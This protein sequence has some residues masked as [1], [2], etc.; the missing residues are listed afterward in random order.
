MGGGSTGFG[1]GAL[2]GFWPQTSG[3]GP[4][5][6]D[7]HSSNPQRPL[8]AHKGLSSPYSPHT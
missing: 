5:L 2:P 4:R 6:Q 8:E 7:R 3:L 1:P